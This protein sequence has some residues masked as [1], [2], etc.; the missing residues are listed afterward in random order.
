MIDYSFSIL[1]FAS[2]FGIVLII[3]LFDLN[4][5][6]KR[7]WYLPSVLSNLLDLVPLVISWLLLFK[8][9]SFQLIFLES[10]F[11][12]LGIFYDRS[13]AVFLVMLWTAVFF[14]K[15]FL[16]L[17]FSGST[18]HLYYWL[19]E[20]LGF[21]GLLIY[22]APGAVQ[23][24]IGLSI[25]SLG[26]YL[27]EA[28]FSS[29]PEQFDR[30]QASYWGAGWAVNLLIAV[31]VIG[32]I[33]S[34]NSERFTVFYPLID[35]SAADNISYLIAAVFLA[36]AVLFGIF[37]FV[38]KAVYDRE[39]VTDR[40]NFFKFYFLL[41]AVCFLL[42]RFNSF[43]ELW[44]PLRLILSIG[45]LFTAL[46]TALSGFRQKKFNH[47]VETVVGSH[48]GMIFFL[49]ALGY[50]RLAVF[51]LFFLLAGR[52]AV[53]LSGRA[54]LGAARTRGSSP[55]EAISSFYLSIFLPLIGLLILAGLPPFW[56]FWV[57][58][59]LLGAIISE[60]EFWSLIPLI[61][62]FFICQLFL[63]FK[64]IRRLL[65]GSGQ[66][67]G[68]QE[69]RPLISFLGTSFVV[70]IGVGGGLL[71]A[72]YFTSPV[73]L[74]WQLPPNQ[75]VFYLVM[76]LL[77]GGLIYSTR[78]V[79]VKSNTIFPG[80]LIGVANFSVLGTICGQ[81]F[82]LLM[83]WL[84]KLVTGW[85]RQGRQRIARLL[86]GLLK[87]SGVGLEFFQTRSLSG[88]CFWGT[89]LFVG[90]LLLVVLFS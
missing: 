25:G 33:M 62:L 21:S 13:S 29:E 59:V 73:D 61:Y 12:D 31:T 24:L 18:L 50:A 80:V 87:L 2:L 37:P 5:A 22:L 38:S 89:L 39:F 15:I 64:L 44:L 56:G 86:G 1:L 6:F 28:R 7:L 43:L 57:N 76:V 20:L 26:L 74:L 70:L 58:L 32:L 3:G 4:K 16:L 30:L 88:Y 60:P 34:F 55:P 40:F 49:F 77:A 78:Y 90:L 79:G 67:G 9:D 17:F 48:L 82:I 75:I 45:G 53:E 69:S 51:Y 52:G 63:L 83:E 81:K 65:K 19:I 8:I 68:V 66:A 54:A 35:L 71:S 10:R 11:F 85:E 84:S 14:L 72:D 46:Q 36:A 27:F 41:P 47:L 23:L 42:L